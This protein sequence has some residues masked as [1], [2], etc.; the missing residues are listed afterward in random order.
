MTET[1]IIGAGPAGLAV[2]A[3][4]RRRGVSHVI[5]ERE[6]TIGSAWRRH[7]DRLHLHTAKSHSALPYLPFP[8]SVPTY[9]SRQEVVEYLDRYAQAFSIRPLLGRVVTRI[10]RDGG[11]WHVE[12]GSER[13]EAACVV[14][15][16]GL[17]RVPYVPTWPGIEHFQGLVC[18]SSSYRN[19]S[20]LRGQRVL[21]VGIGNSGAE[22][23]IDLHEHG[24]LAMIA[25]RGAVNVVPRD[26]L[27][28][29]SQVTALRLHRLPAPLRD[30]I[31]RLIALIAFGDL[32]RLGL[33]VGGDGPA[34]RLEREG[35]VPVIDVGTIALIG[36]GSIRVAPGV[37]RF[38]PDGVV[39]VDGRREAFDAVILATG[40]RPRL[41]DFLEGG[42]GVLDSHGWPPGIEAPSLPGLYFLGLR[43]SP[44]GMLHQIS[45]DARRIADQ[46]ATVVR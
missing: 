32:T 30:A 28:T 34:T 27:G 21:V 17:T 40:Y 46:V 45:L 18:H 19:G 41:D 31:G 2:A 37:A 22:I 38:E 7:Y 11:R 6:A 12:A 5:L 42:T 15:A 39:F 26:F 23:A 8:G 13:H 14:L 33:R 3:C 44:I 16:T 36:S 9:P 43:P 4:L 10:R 29:P 1:I 24:A 35:R 25:V 20:A